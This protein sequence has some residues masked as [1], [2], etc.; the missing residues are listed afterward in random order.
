MPP[1]SGPGLAVVTGASTGIGRALALVFAQHGYD[2]ALAAD[3]PA[4]H[5][6]AAEAQR[7]GI[8][9]SAVEVDLATPDGVEAL[10]RHAV[11]RPAPVT[12]L[13]LNVGIGV[14]GRFDRTGLEDDLRLVDLNVRPTVHLAK[15]LLPGMV[16]RGHGRVLLTSSI[17]GRAPGPYH[18]TY[19]A[20]KAFGHSLA[21]ALR[22]ELR[23]TGVSITSLLPGPTDT[24]FFARAGM[25]ETAVAR[26]SK[27][28]PEDVARQA[29]DA[30]MDGRDHVVTGAFRNTV[31]AVGAAVVPDRIAAAAA[32][33]QTTP[34]KE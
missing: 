16:E 14:H 21:E 23:D 18:A 22:Y 19:A 34:I 6:A 26:G 15:L 20:S 5:Q 31:Q 25:Q 3:E 7:W 24:A 17:A 1:A 11:G 8:V 33:R 9:A 4:V 27:D 30:L 2:L 28:S 13:A 32:A 10:A 29:F 12:A